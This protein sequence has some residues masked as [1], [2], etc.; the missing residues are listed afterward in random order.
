MKKIIFVVLILVSLLSLVSCGEFVCDI[1][2]MQN[3]NVEIVVKL[4][5]TELNMCELCYEKHGNMSPNEPFTCLTCGEEKSDAYGEIV[6]IE[7]EK[8]GVCT[9]C[10][11]KAGLE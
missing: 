5:N 4:E 10:T 11:E 1:C 2:G 7:G 3:P 6:E 9:D 8:V